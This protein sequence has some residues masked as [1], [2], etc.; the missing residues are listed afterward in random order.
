MSDLTIIDNDRASFIGGYGVSREVPPEVIVTSKGYGGLG[1]P[2]TDGII[3]KKD[4]SVTT[5]SSAGLT[6]GLQGRIN[7]NPI[8]G[9]E[10]QTTSNEALFEQGV[11]LVNIFGQNLYLQQPFDHFL[12]EAV[13]LTTTEAI[14]NLALTFAD[15][16]NR[17][18]I[19]LT[20][21]AG[22]TYIRIRVDRNLV[23]NILSTSDPFNPGPGS[24]TFIPKRSP[25][26]T[27]YERHF[28]HDNY[29]EVSD[30]TPATSFES[31][32]GV[33]D[34]Q[35]IV[36]TRS[37]DPSNVNG[38]LNKLTVSK[39]VASSSE[40]AAPTASTRDFTIADLTPIPWLLSWNPTYI[41]TGIDAAGLST[42]TC[43]G[44]SPPCTTTEDLTISYILALGNAVTGTI[45][46]LAV[47]Y[48][49]VNGTNLDITFGP[50]VIDT[51]VASV[52]QTLTATD[53]NVAMNNA[54]TSLPL[55]TTATTSNKGFTPG[56][57]GVA[58]EPS[59]VLPWG[60]T[61]RTMVVYTTSIDTTA[62]GLVPIENNEANLDVF[63]D[64]L[65]TSL[66]LVTNISYKA[67]PIIKS[68][69]TN[70]GLIANRI[71]YFHSEIPLT[72]NSPQWRLSMFS[73][74]N[75]FQAA[76]PATDAVLASNTMAPSCFPKAYNF[77]E[78][79][80]EI[81]GSQD[82]YVVYAAPTSGWDCSGSCY[83]LK[84]TKASFDLNGSLESTLG[85]REVGTISSFALNT[86]YGDMS[87]PGSVATTQLTAA[88]TGYEQDV[89]YDVIGGTGNGLKI[90]VTAVGGLGDV[91][92]FLT[93]AFGTGYD[94]TGIESLT[95]PPT[96]QPANANIGTYAGLTTTSSGTGI[97]AILT[98]VISPIGTVSNV[99]ATS[100]GNSYSPGDTLV[101][102]SAQITG[103][104][105]DLIFTLVQADITDTVTLD[106]GGLDATFKLFTNSN[107]GA[108]TILTGPPYTNAGFIEL[109]MMLSIKA[110][111]DI[112]ANGIGTG[113]TILYVS[114]NDAFSQN[115]AISND[116]GSTWRVEK[117]AP[118]AH[119][120]AEAEFFQVNNN[121]SASK[122]LAFSN[123]I[124]DRD[125]E[126]F[127]VGK[128][129]DLLMSYPVI[130]PN[131]TL[132][133]NERTLGL[134]IAQ[135]SRKLLYYWNLPPQKR[136]A[137][138]ET[139]SDADLPF[140]ESLG[141]ALIT[142]DQTLPPRLAEQYSEN[143][144]AIS[145]VFEEPTL[146]TR[147]GTLVP[148]TPYTELVR[149][150]KYF[151]AIAVAVTH[152][153]HGWVASSLG[154]C[155]LRSG[156]LE[157]PRPTGY[158]SQYAGNRQPLSIFDA[159]FMNTTI[160]GQSPEYYESYKPVRDYKEVNKLYLFQEKVY[161]ETVG[162]IENPILG[163]I[164]RS[165]ILEK[166]VDR[167]IT[168][169]E[170][171]ATSENSGF[172]VPQN[173][174]ALLNKDLNPTGTTGI[175]NKAYYVP[176]GPVNNYSSTK[177][178]LISS[179]LEGVPTRVAKT[180]PAIYEIF[181]SGNAILTDIMG[182]VGLGENLWLTA[183][184]GSAGP[185][186]YALNPTLGNVLVPLPDGSPPFA[187]AAIPPP[188]FSNNGL[189]GAN[190]IQTFL[191]PIDITT[192]TPDK[193][194]PGPL[195][196]EPVSNINSPFLLP[197]FR[198][199]GL[200][201]AYPGPQGNT[202]RK[203]LNLGEMPIGQLT[204]ISAFGTPTFG[205]A[206]TAFDQATGAF[207]SIAP[208][209]GEPLAVTV[210]NTES[211]GSYS[212][213]LNGLPPKGRL[214]TNAGLVLRIDED[215]NPLYGRPS[216]FLQGWATLGITL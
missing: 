92:T 96:Q 122:C 168:R 144:H 22:P 212:Q 32:T 23:G 215:I 189:T 199:S 142:Y 119:N 182:T 108:T 211:N 98:V 137:V 131:P 21:D 63:N 95:L 44:S 61:N 163:S 192:F 83:A 174:S 68:N 42:T 94:D 65:N 59:G 48:M 187:D 79:R 8:G 193:P 62:I 154:L 128:I 84:L 197:K 36:A 58:R 16:N 102:S 74:G 9:T 153:P 164:E 66:T 214:S 60:G 80:G 10:T 69:T 148:N 132:T 196:G 177:G 170:F 152:L 117:V 40:Q 27:T 195:E 120:D 203:Q 158:M 26:L 138:I 179:M 146:I 35:F 72:S 5:V 133:L 110:V 2:I 82:V 216:T 19:P 1:E 155:A 85:F 157:I 169:D 139:M 186:F 123:A 52:Y 140:E 7:G 171:L 204:T 151:D 136:A 97:G 213:N 12:N 207:V 99:V 56:W 75:A 113:E 71:L 160:F 185:P 105:S 107:G 3:I 29:M 201:A 78:V 46:N 115:L 111:R 43:P 30:G 112:D 114:Y 184:W 175:L 54:I 206:V 77:T 116:G 161:S 181:H 198:A 173:D 37:V 38:Y 53:V 191:G 208:Q 141:T 11:P 194:I 15:K 50:Y 73:S 190:G 33:S 126:K 103:A 51:P 210:P 57:T 86:A 28:A 129:P 176:G 70:E 13:S 67:F 150:R 166:N 24:N 121:F 156:T 49:R 202:L 4:L 41:T 93:V 89:I 34:S 20:L 149:A 64:G 81:A 106:G 125:G 45:V 200:G 205:P 90:Q 76:A 135:S 145:A 147:I 165:Q 180:A 134:Q 101:V 130:Q 143:D 124:R 25:F 183:L 178:R 88:G 17:G 91:T 55:T 14:P 47:C 31:I 167:I 172:A 188:P 127:N 162:E 104:T 159:S 209:A 100:A 39:W 118:L 18:N 87:D 109:R 6:G